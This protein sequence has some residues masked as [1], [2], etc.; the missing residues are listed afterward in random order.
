MSLCLALIHHEGMDTQNTFHKEFQF[1]TWPVGQAS[2]EENCSRALC[3]DCNSS[4]C[5]WLSERASRNSQEILN[6]EGTVTALSW[7]NNDA[8]WNQDLPAHDLVKLL[9]VRREGD[10]SLMVQERKE[11]IGCTE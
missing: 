1:S 10:M 6:S 4:L 7:R 8:D 3:R 2:L 11:K 9:G 5:F